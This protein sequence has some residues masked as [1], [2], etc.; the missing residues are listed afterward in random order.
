MKNIQE[1]NDLGG[2]NQEVV[3]YLK[4]I[5]FENSSGIS[6]KFFYKDLEG[7][8]THS[9]EWFL[10]DELLSY[11]CYELCTFDNKVCLRTPFGDEFLSKATT[12]KGIKKFLNKHIL[13][14][15]V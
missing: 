5:N 8:T 9:G 2:F 13:N 4:L 11:S 3:N 12:L 1:S 14:N 6:S 15:S 10:E 7:A